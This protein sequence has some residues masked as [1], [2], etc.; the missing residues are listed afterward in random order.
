MTDFQP[1]VDTSLRPPHFAA[2]SGLRRLAVVFALALA[3]RV[4]L[5]FAYDLASDKP[6]GDASEYV[7][8]AVQLVSTQSYSII[9]PGFVGAP[10]ARRS[11]LFPLLLAACFALF[12][13]GRTVPILLLCL[14]GAGTCTLVSALAR[15]L[16]EERTAWA[17]G[18]AAALYPG[19][20]ITSTGLMTETLFVFLLVALVC[21]ADRI[22]DENLAASLRPSIAAGACAGLLTL[23][24]AEGM[25]VGSLLILWIAIS[26][27]GAKRRRSVVLAA[28]AAALVVAPWVVRNY[29]TFGALIPGSTVGGWVLAGANNPDVYYDE[30]R[31]GGWTAEFGKMPQ[32]ADC[33]KF[34]PAQEPAYSAC[35]TRAAIGYAIDN[36]AR[37]PEL[38][39]WRLRRALDI[40][41]P[42][43]SAFL[44]TMEGRRP[45]F[46]LAAAWTF[47]PVLIAAL[48]GAI[49]FA[50]DIRRLSW[51][52]A[53]PAFYLF[54][55]A[56][57]WGIQR[58]R[59]PMEP[60][61]LLLA[62]GLV[63]SILGR[64][65]ARTAT[66]KSSPEIAP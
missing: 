21:L 14:L 24:R 43:I 26:T 33:A 16:F 2:G 53:I 58:L 52:Y 51:L 23:T 44:E 37:W 62:S 63:V 32:Y 10:T 6:V 12:G 3:V 7:T 28:G 57:T 25:L 27:S 22:A 64:K 11:P 18:L 15:R 45:Q 66:A 30:G 46:T 54:Q 20:W 4:G 1:V 29:I 47:Y 9:H 8:I 35:L 34:P 40:W 31:T 5:C 13:N 19:M 17:A 56:M 61:L 65:A 48:L 59:A 39:L 49:S 42:R 55:I 50:P 38:A 41:D 36:K 60:F